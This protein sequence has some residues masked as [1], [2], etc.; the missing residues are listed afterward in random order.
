MARVFLYNVCIRIKY[1]Y[2]YHE[3]LQCSTTAIV[4]TETFNFT[5]THHSINIKNSIKN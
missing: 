2:H 3:S 4:Y 5:V 1:D